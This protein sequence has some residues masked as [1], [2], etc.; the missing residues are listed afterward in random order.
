MTTAGVLVLALI[1]SINPSAI[2]V[3]LWLLSVAGARASSQVAVYVGAIFVTYFTLGAAVLLGVDLLLPSVGGAFNGTPGLIVQTLV[4]GALLLYGLTAPD[5]PAPAD[6]PPRQAT[7]TYAGLVVLGVTV[8]ALELPTAV[9][10]F[11]ALALMV[12]ARL[13]VAAWMPLLVIYNVIF[14]MPPLALLAGHLFFSRRLSHP[15]DALRSR[16]ER[17]ARSTALWIAGAVGGWLFLTG[18]IEL[19]ARLR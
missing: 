3:T 4:G 19:L 17:G 14:V 10:Y 16:L 18:A 12:Q 1:D 7:R 15:Y 9:P 13:A 8:T 11:A 2:V 5:T 6:A